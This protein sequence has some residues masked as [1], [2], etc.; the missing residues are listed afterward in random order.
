[1]SEPLR[2]AVVEV[3]ATP[4]V[5]KGSEKV[6]TDELA[7]V[8]PKINEL[9]ARVAFHYGCSSCVL[10]LRQGACIHAVAVN[11]HGQVVFERHFPVIDEDEFQLFHHHIGRCLPTIVCNALGDTRLTAEPCVIGHPHV[12]FYAASPIYASSKE[13]YGTLCI[14]D[15]KPKDSFMLDEADYLC[16]QATVVASLLKMGLKHEA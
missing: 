2:R 3:G 1:M 16:D 14:V 9:L 8:G 12:R 6:E 11:E 13:C 5:A 15:T 7:T 4:D 10:A